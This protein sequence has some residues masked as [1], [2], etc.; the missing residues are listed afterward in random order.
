[1]WV[2][3]IFVSQVLNV[4]F[5]TVVNID[6]THNDLAN[7]LGDFCRVSVERIVRSFGYLNILRTA[8]F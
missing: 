4:R 6:F 1:M 5:G 2:K 8:A 3:S 7:G